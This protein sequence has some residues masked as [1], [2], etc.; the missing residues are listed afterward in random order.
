MKIDIVYNFFSK[1]AS[2]AVL[3]IL[4]FVG[5]FPITDIVLG[6]KVLGGLTRAIIAIIW[7]YF[8]FL[9]FKKDSYRL[10][11]DFGEKLII[12][13]SLTALIFSIISGANKFEDYS[14]SFIFLFSYLG[15]N[16]FFRGSVFRVST[17]L[18]VL[19]MS[20]FLALLHVVFMGIRQPDLIISLI[21]L[22]P[23]DV[24]G[25]DRAFLMRGILDTSNT[26]ALQMFIG[27]ISSFSLFLYYLESESRKKCLLFF[28][29]SFLFLSLILFSV[30]RGSL[31]ASM[32]YILLV[33]IQ[34]VKRKHLLIKNIK[35]FVPIVLIVISFFF[36]VSFKYDL[37]E[38]VTSK[39]SQGTT[40]RADAWSGFLKMKGKEFLS[41]EFFKGYGYRGFEQI[42][43]SVSPE[44]TM[45]QLHNFILEMWGRFSFF[46]M[47]VLLFFLS[48]KLFN[49]FKTR[50]NVWYVLAIP[51]SMLGRDFFEVVLFVGIFRWE[52]FFFW[53]MLLT[54]SYMKNSKSLS[55]AKS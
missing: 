43:H 46:G 20:V 25:M 15:I 30:S 31:L 50:S 27:F 14:F 52:M 53:F 13:F 16:S 26:F 5:F 22:S 40:Y 24:T 37:I 44:P 17:L 55:S 23:V 36:V 3:L 34:I 41:L 45:R 39:F 35:F 18:S 11:F 8:L 4:F 2:R 6:N 51:I 38:N 29:F 42:V 1:Y 48:M 9:R 49:N 33:L 10:R 12:V 7:F 19:Y 47:V 54:P 32:I 28:F 21:T